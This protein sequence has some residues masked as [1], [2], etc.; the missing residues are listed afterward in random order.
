MLMGFIC[1]TYPFGELG[2]Y[3]YVVTLSEYEGK[4]LLSRHGSRSTFE[5]QG[6]HIEP[7]ETVWKAAMRELYEES[8]AVEF[9]LL[10]VCDYR[11]G[12]E[13]GHGDGAVFAAHITKLDA[14]P[15]D[16][17]IAEV[18]AF[19]GLP[20]DERLTYPLITPTLYREAE[21]ILF[22]E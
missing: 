20:E 17:E 11:A 12:D 3:K 22:G 16:F 9:T 2:Q 19:D 6:G 7:G 15:E 10:P 13:T 5:T 14:L 1:N 8:G 21:K 18:R 4:L